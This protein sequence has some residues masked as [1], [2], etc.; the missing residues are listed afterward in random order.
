MSTK[1]TKPDSQTGTTLILGGKGKTGSRVA[2]RLSERG[3]PVRIA[4]RSGAQPFD[5]N[6]PSNWAAALRGVRS[7][8]VTYFPDLAV[9][10]AAAHMRQ[11]STLAAGGG[12]ERIVLLSGR[13]EH[14]VFPAEDAVRE[15]GVDFTILRAA[16]F[17]QNFSEGHLL[18][19]GGELAFPAGDVAEPF[20]DIDDIADVAVAA[21]TE[22]GHTGMIYELTGPRLLT[23][24]EAVAEIGRASGQ[25]MRYV[26]ISSEEYARVLAEHVPADYVDFLI[27][28][29]RHVLDGHNAHVTDGVQR[30]LGREPRDFS[31]FARA[32]AAA[33]AWR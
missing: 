33:G 19:Q 17:S 23:F 14:Q 12:V 29:F 15:S 8:Y 27:D 20:I 9:P 16:W 10:D 11:L 18:P 24:A 21:L 7:M 30:A 31:E 1:S 22:P 32:A 4:S 28:L 6:D 25:S 5:W 2:Q 26:P 3:V 13:G